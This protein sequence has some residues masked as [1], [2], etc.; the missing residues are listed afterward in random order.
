[1]LTDKN[2]LLSTANFKDWLE[3]ESIRTYMSTQ[4]QTL[5]ITLIAIPLIYFVLL[6][7]V[8]FIGLSSWLILSASINLYRLWFTRHFAINLTN[9]DTQVLIR[10]K[11]RYAWV[12]PA[13]SAMWGALVWLFYTK[14]PLLNQFICWTTLASIGSFGTF[15]YA[16]NLKL[17]KQFITSMTIMMIGGIAWHYF[18][19]NDDATNEMT[20]AILPLLILFWSL[21]ILT[22]IRLNKSHLQS[23]MMQ[24]GNLDLIASLQDQTTRANQAVETKN[25]FLASAAH[26]IRQPVLALDVYASMLRTEP[27]MAGVLTEKIE[28]ATK[29]VIDMFDSLFDISRLDSGQIK[30]NNS[31]IDVATL[32]RE[33]EVQYRPAAQKKHLQLRIRSG[34]FKIHVDPQLLK[35]ILGNLL[36]N[37]IKFTNRGGVLLAC[38]P[39]Q[40]GV[41]FEVWDTGQG[42]AVDEQAAVF[43][44]FYKSPT[45]LGTSDGFG[46]GLSIVTRLCEAL[47]FH[48]SM[49]S[50]LG[51]GSVFVV[52]V[53]FAAT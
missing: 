25:R 8:N 21:L 20:Y 16:P 13:S 51:R 32:M 19:N 26:D 2:N 39:M 24:K 11:A 36:M 4:Q 44:E 5:I 50:R 27:E 45:H 33:L 28:L 41:R 49:L 43:G 6:G 1:M 10:F 34:D 23:L 30:I 46:L 14:A 48:F 29:S 3:G 37:A 18:L 9:S 38:R 42:I 40:A 52:E 12:Y 31:T 7:H 15:G 22:V 17:A 53:P 47:G 35:R